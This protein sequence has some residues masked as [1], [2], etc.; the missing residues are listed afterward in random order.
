[1]NWGW[2]KY[3]IIAV[4]IVVVYA[5][6]ELVVWRNLALDHFL[7]ES[8]TV[9]EFGDL[10]V[11]EII[12]EE[13]LYKKVLN[14]LFY[15]YE[16]ESKY[17]ALDVPAGK[18]ADM[19]HLQFSG[20]DYL[21]VK[22]VMMTISGDR[23]LYV[24]PKIF[25]LEPGTQ[26]SLAVLILN[27][28]PAAEYSREEGDERPH[29]VH[30]EFKIRADWGSGPSRKRQMKIQQEQRQKYLDKKMKDPAFIEGLSSVFNYLNVDKS[31]LIGK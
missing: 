6:Y 31:C 30:C 15:K 10:K 2:I 9:H 24:Y 23:S 17:K 11:V 28:D 20:Y 7:S 21:L 25:I 3:P 12:D 16:S 14:R 4:T 1:M 19:V 22:D 27:N 13:G 26:D 18:E 5:S 29:I 8:V